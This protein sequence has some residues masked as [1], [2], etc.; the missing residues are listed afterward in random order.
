MWILILDFFL[1]QMGVY[2]HLFY[3]KE[4]LNLEL[5]IYTR[6]TM[7]RSQLRFGICVPYYN[8]LKYIWDVTDSVKVLAFFINAH[9]T[10]LCQ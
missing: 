4:K 8:A 1:L 7:E 3:K 2:S 5:C 9:R 6:T 10:R